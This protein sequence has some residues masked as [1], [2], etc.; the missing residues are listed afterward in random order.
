[1]KLIDFL[2]YLLKRKYT[3]AKKPKNSLEA[4]PRMT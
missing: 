4:L 1:M 2:K 3:K